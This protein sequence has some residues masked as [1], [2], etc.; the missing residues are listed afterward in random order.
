MKAITLVDRICREF[1]EH[2]G[3]GPVVVLLPCQ[4]F[5]RYDAERRILD[6]VLDSGP[7]LFWNEFVMAVSAQKISLGATLEKS[8]HTR[9]AAGGLRIN[10]SKTFDFEMASRSQKFLDD[11]FEAMTGTR[12]P[13]ELA[14]DRSGCRWTEIRVVEHCGIEAPEVY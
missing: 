9:R 1:V 6:S 12:I 10:F 13:I 8:A 3:V 4:V 11:T 2:H 14:F 5:E 7:D